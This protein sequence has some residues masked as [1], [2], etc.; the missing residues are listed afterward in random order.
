MQQAKLRRTESQAAILIVLG[1]RKRGESRNRVTVEAAPSKPLTGFGGGISIQD[2]G[3]LK[4]SKRR[5]ADPDFLTPAEDLKRVR[6]TKMVC[7]IGP[8]SCSREN[9]FRL[10]DEARH[11]LCTPELLPQA[12][13]Y[14]LLIVYVCS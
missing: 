14:Q 7:T 2:A 1:C 11:Q 9:L 3:M 5:S 13:L 4:S 6:K 10:A 12:L 8:T